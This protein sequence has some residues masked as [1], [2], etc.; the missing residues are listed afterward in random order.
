MDSSMHEF[1]A[2]LRGAIE[3]PILSPIRRSIMWREAIL[4]DKFVRT[5]AKRHGS[6]AMDYN[7]LDQRLLTKPK[8]CFYI[9]GSGSSVEDLLPAH[10][11][12][13]AKNVS[14]G[15]NAWAL[16]DFVP[17]IYSFEPVPHRRS[18]HFG[19]MQILNRSEVIDTAKAIL[20]LKPRTPVEEEQLRMVPAALASRVMIHGR[21]QPYT[22]R[23]S[24]LLADFKMIRQLRLSNKTVLLD[25]GASVVRMAFLAMNLGFERIV[26]VGVDLNHTEYFWERNSQYLERRGLEK[27]VSGQ[28]GATHETLSTANRAFGVLDMLTAM[29]DYAVAEGISL[30]VANPRSLLADMLP[31]HDFGSGYSASQ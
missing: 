13:I 12:T 15:I 26:F 20:F 5:V 6:L 1:P 25:S 21:F 7:A 28:L 11:D 3:I 27:F 17:D 24:N 19:T 4:E 22:R 2:G 14:A 23:Q 30:E 8:E 16:H 18:D 31:V 29:R 10:F 9:L